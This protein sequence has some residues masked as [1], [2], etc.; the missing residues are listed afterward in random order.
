LL[1]FLTYASKNYTLSLIVYIALPLTQETR[2][3]E[4]LDEETVS[5]DN[6]V[7]LTDPPPA[8]KTKR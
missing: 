7:G 5:E 2:G 8:P 4:N 6:L 1:P 3:D